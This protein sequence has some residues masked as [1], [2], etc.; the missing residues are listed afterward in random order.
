[1]KPNFY[2]TSPILL[3]YELIKSNAEL[4]EFLFSYME[5]LCYAP[6]SNS[7]QVYIDNKIR[8]ED[9]SRI[10]D[11]AEVRFPSNAEKL[12]LLKEPIPIYYD[13]ILVNDKLLAIGAYL[14]NL[15]KLIGKPKLSL[16]SKQQEISEIKYFKD[17]FI[18][19]S[20]KKIKEIYRQA[21]SYL[22]I[23]KLPQE[24]L[25]NPGDWELTFE[26]KEFSQNI[27][28][29]D[30]P[31][32]KVLPKFTL[33]AIQKNQSPEQLSNWCNHYI[34]KH[35]VNRVVIYNNESI[36][37]SDLPDLHINSHAE[38]WYVE[39]AFT[40]QLRFIACQAGAFIHAHWWIK[41]A[42]SYFL[43]FDPDEYLVNDGTIDI[44]TY[45]AERAKRG[46]RI[47][48][49]EVAP[50]VKLPKSH[51]SSMLKNAKEQKHTTTKYIFAPNYWHVLFV[52]SARRY[53]FFVNPAYW[54][55]LEYSSKDL[56]FFIAKYFYKLDYILGRVFSI[57]LHM[58]RP[59]KQEIYYLHYRSLNTGWKWPKQ[60]FNHLEQKSK[61]R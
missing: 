8:R 4:Q 33:I 30:N 31:F 53:T 5:D 2:R 26:F 56:R 10:S 27:K 44:K 12:I 13:V 52:H 54:T 37:Q 43:N 45:L 51:D 61:G 1:M 38:I 39:W 14:P 60:Y 24:L 22:I 23:D 29:Q 21:S 35:G 32:K 18:P 25:N 48:G 7:L 17:N 46:I 50:S 9:G 16:K 42:A 58:I 19:P 3:P 20:K 47:T 11:K 55:L 40:F 34:E 59:A 49:Y 36:E 15:D 41:K 6:G 28:L 57:L